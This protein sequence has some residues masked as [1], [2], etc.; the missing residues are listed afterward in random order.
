MLNKKLF[1]LI[2]FI[3]ALVLGTGLTSE[4][5]LGDEVYHYRFAKDIFQAGK[6][7]AFDSAYLSGERP[8]YFYYTEPFWHAALVFLWK[9]FGR[10]SFPIAQ[11]YQ[12]LY[13]ALLA[14]FTYLLGKELYGEAT[15]FYSAL[16]VA[17][18]PVVAAFGILFYVDLPA[19]VLSTLCLY[20]IVKK[21][22][23]WSGVILGMMYLTKRSTYF[24]FPAFF[25]LVFFSGEN[26]F[27][28]K[29]RNLIYILIP[30]FLF[31]LPDFLWRR[32]HLKAL[33]ITDRGDA[34]LNNGDLIGI[35]N[36]LML[37]DWGLRMKE[38]LNSSL[39]NP[40]DIIKYF[41]LVL[42]IAL[43]LYAFLK[44]YDRRDRILWLP[45]ICYLLFF[46]YVF[47][48]GSDIRYLLPIV[49][50]LAILSS[51]AIVGYSNKKSIKAAIFVL[52]ALQLTSSVLYVRSKRQIP[53]GVKEGFAY[54]KNNT[55]SDAL[56]IYPEY[57]ILEATNRKVAW[58][59]NLPLV[60]NDFFWNKDEG[61][62]KRLLNLFSVGYIAIKKSRIYDDSKIHNY[63][64][65]PKSFV[66]RLPK[67]SFVKLVF[68]NKEMSIWKIE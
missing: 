16:I 1:L 17:T 2:F 58:S 67:L 41:G 46:S 6:R 42:M 51:K 62:V 39:L 24:F 28:S 64:G 34:V 10:I 37:S 7:V 52:C 43:A 53:K 9:V 3:S 36:R 26:N 49:P 5:S 22:F 32:N 60:R 8:G 45:V 23:F 25:L 20:T 11:F 40:L 33:S 4:L 54:I 65:Y 48:P 44:K 19:A 13:Y 12:T 15:G 18:A 21:R 61:A 30:V 29:I 57:V 66:E 55:P 63:N 59:G 35:K 68:D 50:L 27:S 38:Y 56:I 31:I 47:H 14:L